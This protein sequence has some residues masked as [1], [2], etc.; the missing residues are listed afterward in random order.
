MGMIKDGRMLRELK[1]PRLVTTLAPTQSLA[2]AWSVL[3]K[4]DIFLPKSF[5]EPACSQPKP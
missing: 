1:C 5:V 3:A 2:K 4:L